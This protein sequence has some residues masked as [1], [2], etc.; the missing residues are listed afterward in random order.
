M[1]RK[2]SKYFV[3]LLS[4]LLL[5][6]LPLSGCGTEGTIEEEHTV[7]VFAMGTYMTLTAYG[8]SAEAALTLSKDRIKELESLW[9]TT[10]DNSDIYKVNQSSGTRTEVSEETAE[11]LQFALDMAEQ[12]NGSL[13]PTISPVV[14]AWGFI[15]GEYHIPT[16]DELTD[17]LQNTD[18]KKVLLEE[19]FVTLPDG[20]QLDLG[21]VG[22]GY[23]GDIIAEL[24]KEQG[25][26][27]A[28]LDI[29]GNIQ[30]VGRK[31]DGSRWRLGIQNPFGE[32][33]LGILES[34][35]GAVVTSG[36]YERYFIGEDGKQYGHII[37]PS[38]GYPV[39]SGLAS[40]SIIAKEGKL[41]DAL[42]TAI[43]VMGLEEA[44]EYWKA[45]SSFEMLL[46]TDENEIY[47]TEGIKDDFTLS[48][49]FSDM[50]IC[51]ITK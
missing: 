1:W 21:A 39:E 48:D 47:L 49:N 27:S 31:P 9:S 44:T 7:G 18:Y 32:G 26:T 41:C 34:E 19:N 28:L 45:N 36:N 43:Y 51:V 30:M 33:S 4:L 2:S 22:K 37:D 35:D 46:V 29:G 11:I 17:L 6:V 50:E 13:E 14:T 16:E 5:F 12:T 15:S 25:V 23:T 3:R 20:M 24:L 10:D 40:V 38:T 8:E 42:S